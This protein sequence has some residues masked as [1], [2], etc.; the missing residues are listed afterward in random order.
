MDTKC[1]HCSSELRHRYLGALSI[2]CPEC[3]ASLT[4]NPHP[5]EEVAT[6]LELA[7]YIAGA[8]GLLLGYLIFR[9]STGSLWTGVAAAAVY[10]SCRVV[11]MG[12]QI[13]PDWKRWTLASKRHVS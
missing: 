9:S 8:A 13:P 11:M 6:W 3:K 7:I 2:H 5:S 12:K 10:G 4:R 1:P